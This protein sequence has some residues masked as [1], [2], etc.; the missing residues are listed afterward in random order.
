MKKHILIAVLAAAFSASPA[1]AALKVGDTAPDFTAAGSLG[2][3]DVNFNLKTALKKGPVVVYFY[4]SAYT[5]GC[6]LQARTFAEESDKFTAAGVSGDTLDRLKKYSADPKFCAGKFT[7]A[8]DSDTKVAATYNLNV[9]QPGPGTKDNQG[10]PL[11]HAIIER[12]TYVIGKDG[13][14]IASM[15]STADG[16]SPVEH[17]EKS[18]AVVSA[19]K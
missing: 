6:D 17:V 12:H 19:A 10:N 1:L 18:L 4:P 15:S 16:I 9:R 11:T 2:G 14:I 5:G 7:V 3:K 8:S 13:K